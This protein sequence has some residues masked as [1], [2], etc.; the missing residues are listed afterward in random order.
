MPA[1]GQGSFDL[2]PVGS[3]LVLSDVQH[4]RNTGSY[5]DPFGAQLY[6]NDAAAVQRLQVEAAK[7]HPATPTPRRLLAL[8][9]RPKKK[10]QPFR[11]TAL[12]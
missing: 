2:P 9:M 5:P 6:H 1:Q 11:I 7:E 4:E 8:Y 12:F 3:H 10:P